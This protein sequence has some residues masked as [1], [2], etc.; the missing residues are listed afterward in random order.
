M[1][2]YI[3]AG[4]FIHSVPARDLTDDEETQHADLIAQQQAA[5]GMM[6]YEPV[7]ASKPKTAKDNSK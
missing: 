4:A 7:K 5:S 3:G 6:L 2:K 1:L